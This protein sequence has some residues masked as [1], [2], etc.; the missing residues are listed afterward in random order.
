MDVL[1]WFKH[2]IYMTIGAWA[3][4]ILVILFFWLVVEW[5]VAGG[6]VWLGILIAI[7]RLLGRWGRVRRR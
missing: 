5:G 7:L 2:F 6:L 1:A 3:A 4:V